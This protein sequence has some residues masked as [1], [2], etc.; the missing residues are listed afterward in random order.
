MW[1]T[2]Q[3]RLSFE[4]WLCQCVFSDHSSHSS[5]KPPDRRE[6]A[7]YISVDAVCLEWSVSGDAECLRTDVVCFFFVCVTK[8][9]TYSSHCCIC[10]NCRGLSD[11]PNRFH[12][13]KI[14]GCL[15]PSIPTQRERGTEKE[16]DRGF[17]WNKVKLM[18]NLI[19]S[20][21]Q[22]HVG[23]ILSDNYISLW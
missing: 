15:H 2:W 23:N 12:M 7:S 20:S 1:E 14:S 8:C 22:I 5:W 18:S 6:L 3:R 13:R 10:C 21:K 17:T 19:T 4:V 11:F 16:R 9:L